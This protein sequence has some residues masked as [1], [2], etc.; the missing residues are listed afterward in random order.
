MN[1]KTLKPDGAL[2]ELLC[3]VW[4]DIQQNHNSSWTFL[5][6]LD[7][8][9]P[10]SAIFYVECALYA[11]LLFFLSLPIYNIFRCQKHSHLSTKQ[12][13]MYNLLVSISQNMRLDKLMERKKTIRQQSKE[14]KPPNKNYVT[15]ELS[16]SID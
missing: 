6:M 13:F 16:R 4:S 15:R 10:P 11:F 3:V 2:Q 14:N 9:F 5:Q 12:K 8:F 1:E 7:N